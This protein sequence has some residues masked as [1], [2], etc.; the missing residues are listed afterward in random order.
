MFKTVNFKFTFKCNLH[1]SQKMQLLNVNIQLNMKK[2]KTWEISKRKNERKVREPQNMYKDNVE[3]KLIILIWY[4]VF[5][6]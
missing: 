1:F 3:K 6:A 4:T 5:T 2:R